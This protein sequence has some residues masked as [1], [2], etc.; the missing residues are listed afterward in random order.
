MLPK[1]IW[2]FCDFWLETMKKWK[3]IQNIFQLLKSGTYVDFIQFVQALEM[4]VHKN[5]K[6]DYS[7]GQ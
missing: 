3:Y 2:W 4:Y 1:I 6:L 7:H 5:G